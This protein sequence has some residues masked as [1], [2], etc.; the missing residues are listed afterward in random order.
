MDESSETDAARVLLSPLQLGSGECRAQLPSRIIPGPMES[1]TAGAWVSQLS[2]RQWVKC[3]WT[4]FLRIST[5]VPRLARLKEWLRPFHETGLPVVAQL[6]G[7]NAELIGEAAAGLCQAGAVAVDLNCACPSPAVVG[8]H[9]G[10]YCLQK[11]EWLGE[12]LAAM[13][14]STA[15]LRCPVGVKVRMGWRSP[16]E[17][18]AVIAPVLRQAAPDFVTV[19]FRTVAELYRPVTEGLERMAEVRKELPDVTLIGSGDLFTPQ[20]IFTMVQRCGVDAVAPAR[21]LLRNPRMIAETAALLE[22]QPLPPF[23]HDEAESFLHG[24]LQ[25]GAPRGFILQM[26]ANIY[27]KGSPEFQRY[28]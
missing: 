6:M 20:D 5:G 25:D 1:V 26:A 12:A 14:R 17:F 11:P 13:R 9:S 19:H 18:A 24:C 22:G 7:T 3:W 10:G 27:G 8:N 28:L 16:A 15:P 21:G 2:A 23:G 4:P